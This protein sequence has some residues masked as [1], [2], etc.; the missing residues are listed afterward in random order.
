MWLTSLFTTI[1]RPT[2]HQHPL[3]MPNLYLPISTR[4]NWW[5]PTSPPPIWQA[6]TWPLPPSTTLS[7][8]PPISRVR[9]SRERRVLR[10]AIWPKQSFRQRNGSRIAII[11]KHCVSLSLHMLCSK[12]CSYYILWVRLKKAYFV[13][14]SP[15][16][17]LLQ[18]ASGNVQQFYQSI[19]N[20]Y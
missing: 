13:A 15:S 4:A 10:H 8:S 16:L 18:Q 19:V 6:A 9:A 2:W 7:S 20:D 5:E 11:C 14:S 17:G 3:G 1:Q 12:N